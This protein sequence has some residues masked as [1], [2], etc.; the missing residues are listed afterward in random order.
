MDGREAVLS[1][2][3]AQY[4]QLVSAL[5]EM[6]AEYE[7][8]GETPLISW[9]DLPETPSQTF[10]AGEVVSQ[11]YSVKSF[12]GRGG[13]GEV[14]EVADRHLS[15][16]GSLALK[17]VRND[18]ARNR[19]AA[20]RF[21]REVRNA[22]V[23]AHP[24]VCRIFDVGRHLSPQG[25]V[26]YLTM[27][28]LP[29]ATL[30]SWLK[31]RDVRRNPV[32]EAEALPL[33]RQMAAGLAAIHSRHIIHR[34]FK[35]GNV[36]L[37]LE[38]GA[39]PDA[40]LRAVITDFGLSRG[41]AGDADGDMTQQGI[42]IGTP[43]FMAPEQL[44]GGGA[45][46]AAVDVYALG[47]TAHEMLTGRRLEPGAP[48]T[49]LDNA[50][51]SPWL[52][53]VVRK[54]LERDPQERYA[55]GGQVLEALETGP[56]GR[57]LEVPLS[58]SVLL[59]SAC[60]GALAIALIAWIVIRE[61]APQVPP[62]VHDLVTR[63]QSKIVN[64]S[65][66]DASTLLGQAAEKAPH[67]ATVH[68]MLADAYNG[69]E[70]TSKANREVIR[71]ID[72]NDLR[73]VTSDER[74][75]IEAIRLTM[76]REYPAAADAFRKYYENASDGNRADRAVLLGRALEMAREPREAA[77]VYQSAGKRAPAL[78]ALAMMNS[79]ERNVALSEADFTTARALFEQQGEKTAVIQA[80]YYY[81]N[82]LD[83]WA[84]PAEAKVAFESCVEQ[85]RSL[86]DAYDAL[87]CEEQLSSMA[88]TVGPQNPSA[89]EH[90]LNNQIEEA[91]RQGYEIVLGRAQ[92]M[93]GFLNLR[94]RNYDTAK[95][96]FRQALAHADAEESL[97]LR[98][99][100]QQ[101]LATADEALNRPKEAEVEA[102]SALAFYDNDRSL[103]EI[104]ECVVQLV[105]ALSDQGKLDEASAVL[106][107]RRAML[108]LMAP[109]ER[110]IV[111]DAEAQITVAEENPAETLEII[112]RAMQIEPGADF[113]R[114]QLWLAHYRADIGDQAGAKSALDA[115]RQGGPGTAALANR[116]LTLEARLALFRGDTSTVKRLIGAKAGHTSPDDAILLGLARLRSGEV[117]DAALLCRGQLENIQSPLDS[118]ARL[119]VMEVEA[120]LKDAE[121][122]D[123]MYD[124][125]G[126]V[127]KP[128][129]ESRWRADAL[130]LSVE[131]G[132][133]TLR[134][135]AQKHFADVR[136]MWGATA[137][138]GY[139]TRADVRRI[140]KSAG[141]QESKGN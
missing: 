107:S 12:L 82:A 104:A 109:R 101:E 88:V 106:N 127:W 10:A 59:V 11:R 117:T 29:G 55:D 70:L 128:Q 134:D 45:L 79:R 27:E 119:C 18:L 2:C 137:F 23:V 35:P 9:F 90:D 28:Y 15:E 32:P 60:V 141:I 116:A 78:L 50:P 84:R 19:E 40:P 129:V 77:V 14:Y 136:T 72:S 61:R 133:T 39:T 87:R 65:F 125:I 4:P 138:S 33:I 8:A 38:Q 24:N 94:Q 67:D 25:P 36:M 44:S 73:H 102:R 131:P 92:L 96:W 46:T 99:Q 13:M 31:E 103:R 41:A 22:L 122:V 17:T 34:D 80:Q 26:L 140:M 16:R 111:T 105:S 95:K 85:A 53:A 130:L 124:L 48:L 21:E 57:R 126:K 64:L 91:G 5:E 97:R 93:F 81:G 49:E 115:L 86:D 37:V 83:R 112:E 75:Y 56:A 71:A 89:I 76:A 30:A 7:S 139:M 43:A 108:P 135:N 118:D 98:A 68:A 42:A 100:S 114:Y 121:G 66:Y 47:V 113:G 132:Y 52:R 74:K 69:L 123:K 51:L 63:A 54:C 3:R 58:R 1:E 6:I 62:E 120:A 20:G 110:R